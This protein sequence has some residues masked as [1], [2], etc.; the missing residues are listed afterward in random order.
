MKKIFTTALLTCFAVTSTA[1]VIEG[2]LEKG[3]TYSAL[4]GLSPESGDLVGYAFKNQSIVGT[5]ILQSC[6]PGM[7]CELGKASVRL[8]DDA[9]GLKFDDNP[10]GWYEIIKAL[11]IGMK[12]VVFGYKKSLKTRYGVV[13][14]REEDKVL[15]FRGKPV[16]PAIEGGS[17]D[18]IQHRPQLRGNHILG[19]T[20]F[21]LLQR[22]AH[23]QDRPQAGID[24]SKEL[25]RD[26]LA[27]FVMV[28]TALGM[29]DQAKTRPHIHQHFCRHLAG[30]GPFLVAADILR[31]EG[32]RGVL[33]ILDQ[34]TQIWQRRQDH[35]AHAR[36]RQAGSHLPHQIGGELTA[37]MQ[38]PVTGNNFLS[39]FCSINVIVFV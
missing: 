35:H 17:T 29:T 16:K 24:G 27:G 2:V 36:Q 34:V 12:T 33:E 9:T 32:Q 26:M 20:G 22:L 30:V 15:L 6:L 38:L 28:L 11:D 21:A 13:S 4:F 23:A 1:D 18:Q 10:S 25:A 14:V 19:Q 5:A 37:A 3:L 39:H 8:L 7:L 31:T